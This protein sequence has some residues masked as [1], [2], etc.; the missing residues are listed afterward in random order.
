MAYPFLLIVILICLYGVILY[1]PGAGPSLAVG[2]TG[3][4]IAGTFTSYVLDNAS[5]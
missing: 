2:V 1:V 4:L 3:S 5:A